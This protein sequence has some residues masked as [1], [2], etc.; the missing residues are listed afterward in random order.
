MTIDTVAVLGLGTMGHGIAQCFALAGLQVRCFDEYEPMRASLRERVRGN[1][2]Q[3]ARAGV[4]HEE[5][6]EPAL[7]KLILCTSKAETVGAAQFV[8]EAVAEDLAIKQELFA[9]LEEHADPACILASNSSSFPM[10]QTAARMRRPERAVVTH[11]FNPPHIAPVVEVVPGEKTA[12]GCMDDTCALLARIG[13]QPVRLTREIPGF[14]VNRVQ[15]AMFREVWDL[16]ERGI[17]SA[18]EI[19]RA[20]RGS[21]GFRLAALGPLAIQDFAGLD[22]TGKVYEVLIQDL[23]SDRELPEVIRNLLETGRLGTKTGKG[24]FDYTPEELERQRDERDRLYLAI[25]KL[26]E[27]RSA[28]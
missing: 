7:A 1:L 3:M 28:D 13:K 17:A 2:V 26:L 25:V 23:R 14:L 16:L 15:I 11:W 9:Q 18:A 24:F 10:T 27:S 22:I 8:T 19:D 5:V 20:I 12:L 21:M 4:L 6:I